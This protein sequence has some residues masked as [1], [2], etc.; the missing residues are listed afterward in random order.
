[1]NALVACEVSEGL[2]P[3]EVTVSVA[4]VRGKRQF[5]RVPRDFLTFEG[6]KWFLPVGVIHDD[7]VGPV[8]VEFPHEA[9]S[10][11]NRIWV[12]REDYHLLIPSSTCLPCAIVG[13]IP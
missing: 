1:M 12:A 5:L 10:G 2:R 3:S 13:P 4:D 6:G 11:A 7:R 9:D 8:L